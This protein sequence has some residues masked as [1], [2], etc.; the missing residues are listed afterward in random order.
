MKDAKWDEFNELIYQWIIV[1][2]VGSIFAG[3][4]DYLYGMSSEKIG[5]DV[6]TL[7]FKSII[8]KDTGFFDDR[9]VG[10]ILSR[11]TSDT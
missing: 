11:L 2:A 4:R 7:F 9:K 6:R 8:K 1:I 10:D 5:L 3:I